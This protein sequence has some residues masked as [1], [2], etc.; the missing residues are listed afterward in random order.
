MY[1]NQHVCADTF[2]SV[3][4]LIAAGCA[5]LIPALTPAAADAFA[6]FMVSIIII[7]S[8]GPL[9]QGLY[10]TALE[11]WEMSNGHEYPHEIT[12]SV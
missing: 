6:S 11:I 8:L 3:A 2:R 4:V 10:Y 7:V 1:G 5:F 9:I 12:L